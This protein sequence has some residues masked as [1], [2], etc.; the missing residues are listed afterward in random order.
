MDLARRA[1]V[2]LSVVFFFISSAATCEWSAAAVLLA[3]Q[4]LSFDCDLPAG[5]ETAVSFN[6][7]SYHGTLL[8]VFLLDQAN[9]N[10]YTSDFAYSCI[11]PSACFADTARAEGSF[12]LPASDMGLTVYFVISNENL[13]AKANVTYILSLTP[14][15][16]SQES[17]YLTILITILCALLALASALFAVWL[18]R[19]RQK[20]A[21]SH[22]YSAVPLTE[23]EQEEEDFRRT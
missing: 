8:D 5:R 12:S 21:T 3:N 6:V 14:G 17:T 19:R 18:V 7:S 20:R 16:R 4:R 13:F 10:L 9:Y 23:E 15:P 2:Y 22:E 1:S 11:S